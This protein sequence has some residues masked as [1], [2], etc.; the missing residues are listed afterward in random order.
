MSDI[1]QFIGDNISLVKKP[2][3]YLGG[4]YNA[5]YKP[6]FNEPADG[7][8][9]VLAF[10]D[11]Y[12]IGMSHMGIRLLYSILNSENNISCDRA[13]FPYPDM[14]ASMKEHG[15]PMFSI[16]Q[17]RPLEEFDIIGFSIQYELCY[18]TMLQMLKYGN[19]GLRSLNRR[20]CEP[21]V[22]AGGPVVSNP[23]PVA[24][25]MDVIFIGDAEDT[26]PAF[27]DIVRRGRA[28]GKTRKE[29]LRETALSIP[30]AYVPAFYSCRFDADGK[31]METV[32]LEKGIPR[33]IRK[34]LIDVTACSYPEKVIVPNVEIVHNRVSLEIMRGCV[35]GCR[36]C[37]AGYFYR[38]KREK[39]A[40]ALIEAAKNMLESSGFSEISLSSL[41]SVDYSQLV[42]V[43]KG[44]GAYSTKRNISIE[45]PSSRLDNIDDELLRE[46][47][48]VKKGGLTIAPEAGTQRMRDVVNKNL[49]DEDIKKA[50][51]LAAVHRW[52]GVKLYFMVGL[53]T[54]TP[55]DL[56]GIARILNYAASK[57]LKVRASVSV[58]TPKVHT[59][60]Q[61]E[62]QLQGEQLRNTYAHIAKLTNKK[63][64]LSWR[65]E[66]LSYL[67]G[68]FS[69]ADRR[70]SDVLEDA[71]SEG[72]CLD[73]WSEYFDKAAWMRILEKHGYNGEC[74][75]YAGPDDPLPWDI[76][77]TGID[78]DFFRSE[79]EKAYAGETT[80]D[81]SLFCSACGVCGSGP[82]LSLSDSPGIL[83]GPG[84][85]DDTAGDEIK[86]R[87]YFSRGKDMKYLSQKDLIG[88]VTSSLRRSGL[89]LAFSKGFS[90][91][92]KLSFCNPAPL[93]VE[94]SND[95]FEIELKR[96][97]KMNLDTINSFFPSGFEIIRLEEVAKGDKISSFFMETASF[98]FFPR[99]IPEIEGVMSSD[100]RGASLYMKY[101]T[102]KVSLRKI[103]EALYGE[104]FRRYDIHG[105]KR[106]M[107]E[108]E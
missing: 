48:S 63:V 12:E 29:I 99:T 43:M 72:I 88:V 3:R 84:H 44:I 74:P 37:H 40:D 77:D 64:K 100:V 38:P 24:E 58:F 78:N 31:Y 18:A 66:Y 27:A 14:F 70:I 55:E 17:R 25:F 105:V 11:T 92:P 10:P 91:H 101:D 34:N 4:E 50:I 8:N 56:D 76:V 59:P 90:P 61:W 57:R 9:V 53:P 39:N 108:K 33:R 86:M 87:I 1:G 51:D 22:V 67:E 102:R 42:N 15:I 16:E 19:V 28:A 32:P 75:Q 65:D 60:F 71:V 54:E 98:A 23:E 103:N 49:S 107:I 73:G 21:F 41:S 36:F 96:Y 104:D 83:P 35:H 52:N 5:S 81:C 79:R 47:S 97:K 82:A 7:V 46:L 26:L 95:F 85:E 80:P 13:Y 69:R 45:L 62:K 89:D 68:L 20:E 30:S 93:G 6:F 2:L 106:E 94:T